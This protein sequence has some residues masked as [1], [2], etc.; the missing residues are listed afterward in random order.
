MGFGILEGAGV[1]KLL[2]PRVTRNEK[3]ALSGLKGLEWNFGSYFTHL[4][5]S[6]KAATFFWRGMGG[7]FC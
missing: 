4:E 5:I 6:K 1:Y 7:G 3:G 2:D